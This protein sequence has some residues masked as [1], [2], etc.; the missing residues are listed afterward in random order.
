[1]HIR[2]VGRGWMGGRLP[3]DWVMVDLPLPNGAGSRLA[4]RQ[5]TGV[6]CNQSSSSRGCHQTELTPF[7]AWYLVA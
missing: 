3:V 6:I 7:R 1:M 4:D 2:W 5:S